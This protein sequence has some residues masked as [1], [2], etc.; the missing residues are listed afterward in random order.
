MRFSGF[1]KLSSPPLP[2]IPLLETAGK[3]AAKRRGRWGEALVLALAFFFLLPPAAFAACS[4]PTGVAGEVIYNQDAH[5]HQYCNDTSWIAMAAGA[6]DGGAGATPTTSGLIGHWML[7]DGSG[8]TAADSAGS[9]NGTLTNGPTWTTGK[10]SGAVEFDGTDDLVTM[11]TSADILGNATAASICFWMKYLPSSVTSDGAVAATYSPGWMV[12]VDD[13][14]ANSGRQNTLSFVIKN[15]SDYQV[16]G[17]NNLITTGTWDQYCTTFQASSFMRIYKNGVMDQELTTVPATITT[18]SNAFQFG[19][20]PGGSRILNAQLD[21]IRIYN[22]ALSTTEIQQLYS[23]GQIGGGTGC[24]APAGVEGSINFNN[25]TRKLQYCDGDEWR[26]MGTCG[27]DPES[28][29]VAHWKLDE[30]SGTSAADSSGNGLTGT[31]TNGPVWQSTGGQIGGALSF[32]GSNDYVTIPDPGT[33]SV[34]DFTTGDSI[35]VSAWINPTS[36]TGERIITCKGATTGVVDHNYCLFQDAGTLY[37]GFDD[38]GGN[39]HGFR[40]TATVLGTGSWQHVAA[41]FIFNSGSSTDGK[42]YYNGSE[43]PVST[44]GSN[45]YTTAPIVQDRPQWLGAYNPSGSPASV[46]NGLID[47]VRIYRRILSATDIKAIYD[48]GKYRNL[49][50][51]KVAHWPFDESTGT[52]VSDLVGVSPGTA[53][54]SPTWV[55]TGGQVGGAMDFDGADDRVDVG[56]DATLDN[57]SAMTIVAWIK[58]DTLGEGP[59]LGRIIGKTSSAGTTTAGGWTLNLDTTNRL[60]FD[61]D[62]NTTDFR[63][64]AANNSIT[65]NQW[66]QVAVTWTGSATATNAKL[67]VNGVETSYATTTNGTG[68]RV[69]D[70]AQ[71]ISIGNPPGRTDRTFD[72]KIDN[73]RIYNRALSAAEI[74]TLYDT[75]ISGNACTTAG[76]LLY[77]A[78]LNVMKSCDGLKWRGFGNCTGEVAGAVAQWKFDETSG[79]TASDSSGNSLNG[80]LTNGPVWSSGALTLDGTDDYVSVSDPGAGSV[81]DFASGDSI[82]ITAWINPNT[83][84]GG[85]MIF[86]TKSGTS[87]SATSNYQFETLGSSLQ[88]YFT[89]SGSWHGLTTSSGVLT[90]GVWQFVAF[91]GTFGILQNAKAYVNGVSFAM[92]VD[93][94]SPYT[95]APTL[96]N[97]PLWIGAE[98]GGSPASFFDGQMDDIRIY[99]RILSSDEIQ[100]LY[101]RGR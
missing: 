97:E 26:A 88:F 63:Q 47:D 46:F 43:F 81:L 98:N 16:E 21:D 85:N 78:T 87:G 1:S 101:L 51:G 59:S 19:Q 36:I 79:T 23:Y 28:T 62:Y 96:A 13:V 44:L 33:G 91:T 52:T 60:T 86:V 54:N 38:S 61:V 20:A 76:E 99:R 65:L 32:D 75:T 41:T 70:S 5:V 17:S 77:D 2:L 42:L 30:S 34:L 74:A 66:Q 69:D 94:G 90:T 4:S 27:E 50:N 53:V 67:Y 82:T 48:Q 84:P 71:S 73:V 6:G 49:D 56:S 83:L 72:G 64:R 11:G 89:N 15:G 39:F 100:N 93:S 14:A 22:R 9:H 12:W 29:K 8:T 40:T 25:D 92:S 57:L 68:G 3:N 7:D 37:F 95:T 45:V 58:P 35:T 80:T 55:P 31:L 10:M 18:S 24:L